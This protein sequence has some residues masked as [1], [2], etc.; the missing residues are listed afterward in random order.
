MLRVVINDT[1]GGFGLSPE[2]LLWLLERGSSLIIKTTFDEYGIE[3]T[4]EEIVRIASEDGFKYKH[5]KDTLYS[6]WYGS[7]VI[8]TATQTVYT[9]TIVNYN[10]QED[11]DV[12]TV[13]ART[14]PDLFAV[15]AAL[16]EQANG[17]HARLKIVEIADEDVTIDRIKISEYDGS[18][19]IAERHRTW[20]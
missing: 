6:T 20:S 17:D 14:H 18:E 4:P 16:G 12:Q 11:W 5:I 2:A 3:E 19:W 9:A 15:I 13:R 1:Y 10:D 7:A 8:D